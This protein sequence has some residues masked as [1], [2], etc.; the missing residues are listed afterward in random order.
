MRIRWACIKALFLQALIPPAGAGENTAKGCSGNWASLSTLSVTQTIGWRW[1]SPRK[2]ACH[3]NLLLDNTVWLEMNGI[4][5][6]NREGSG[7]K[8]QLC[9]YF[10]NDDLVI[11]FLSCSF[12][13][14]RITQK[15][16]GFFVTKRSFLPLYLRGWGGAG[17]CDQIAKRPESGQNLVCMHLAHNWLQL[18]ASALV[19]P[20]A[21]SRMVTGVWQP[22]RNI[23]MDKTPPCWLFATLVT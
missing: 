19:E 13:T 9:H 16:L 12:W 5:A 4:W 2:P 23:P 20:F 3:S 7:L 1:M 17:K 15:F 21:R 22:S 11:C 18:A 8:Q 14:H 6:M 10:N